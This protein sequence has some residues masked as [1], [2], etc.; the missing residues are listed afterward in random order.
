MIIKKEIEGMELEI[1]DIRSKTNLDEMEYRLGLLKRMYQG[2]L[3]ECVD[4]GFDKEG[5]FKIVNIG[6]IN[7]VVDMD[8][9]F[10]DPF[11]TDLFSG[12][13]S[14]S[15]KDMNEAL[16]DIPSADKIVEEICDKVQS[17]KYEVIDLMED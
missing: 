6:R 15:I 7:R 17:K 13:M 3:S 12:Y 4:A 10:A 14:L 16:R 8:R 11:L 1:A 2:S 9:I 5:H